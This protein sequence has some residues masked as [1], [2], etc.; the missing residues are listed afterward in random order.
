M[1]LVYRCV[2]K[3]GY[4]LRLRLETRPGLAWRS[5]MAVTAWLMRM[6]GWTLRY[7][8]NDKAGYFTGG[9][10]EPVI[11]VLWHNRIISTPACFE[12]YNRK[13]RSA[14]VL[15]SASPEGSLLALLMAHFGIGA[16]RGSTSRRASV[17][18]R[19]MAARMAEGHDVMITPDGPRGPRYRLQPGALFLAQKTG[20]S[21]LPIHVEYSHYR[22]FKTW[23]G[24]A[25]PLPFAR[26]EVI[27]DEPFRV[28]SK[29]EQE[30]E[31]E[32]RQ[33]ER[34]MTQSLR[35]D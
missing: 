34:R 32:R 13:K 21:I 8:V 4:L 26:V 7:R 14:L 28:S 29:T 9:L 1:S 27:I 33:L 24:F 5:A 6:H 19:E 23:D 15:T 2:R 20:Y 3:V 22:R 35:M 18:L 11:I 16:V 31:I 17:A 10:H 12:R 30:F 25:L